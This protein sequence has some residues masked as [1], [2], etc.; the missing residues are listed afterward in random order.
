MYLQP[1]KKSALT[2]RGF[3]ARSEHMRLR[4]VHIYEF[5]IH[6]YLLYKET[7]YIIYLLSTET[8][9]VPHVGDGGP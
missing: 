6:I 9:S 7:C 4:D 3:K 5:L 8:D 2:F 1:Y